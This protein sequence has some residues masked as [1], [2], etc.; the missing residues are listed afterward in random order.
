M[1]KEHPKTVS[2]LYPMKWLK[3]ADLPGPV[4]VRIEGISFEELYDQQAREYST[5]LVISFVGARKRLI[6]NKTQCEAIWEITGSENFDDWPGCEV[7]LKPGRARN[8]K[9]TIIIGKAGGKANGRG[10]MPEQMVIRSAMDEV[11]ADAELG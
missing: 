1:R 6:P 7:E 5:K 2:E 4:V 11:E 3:A 8:G 10:P 9:P